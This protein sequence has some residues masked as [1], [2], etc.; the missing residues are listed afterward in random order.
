MGI[1][2]RGLTSAALVSN[3]STAAEGNNKDIASVPAAVDRATSVDH[4]RHHTQGYN[5]KVG[6]PHSLGVS[7]SDE[8]LTKVDTTAARGVQVVQ[9]LTHV[10]SRNELIV[11]YILSVSRVFQVHQAQCSRV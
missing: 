5:E 9:A 1:T 3:N 4:G 10:W 7:D 8:D 2:F 11:A 6:A